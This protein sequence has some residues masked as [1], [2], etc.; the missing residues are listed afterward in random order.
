MNLAYLYSKFFKKI[1]RGKSIYKCKIAPTAVVNS[2]SSMTYS[3]IGRFSYCG[4]DCEINQTDIGAFCSISDHVFIGGDEHPLDWVSTSSMFQAV[5]H[6]G[7]AK[8]FASHEVPKNKRTTIGSDVWIGHGV[9]IKQGV[10]IGHGA[11]IATGAVVTKDVPPYA[12]VGGVPAKVIRY[13]FDEQT[14][15]QLLDSRWWEACEEDIRKMAPY[16]CNPYEF[17]FKIKDYNRGNRI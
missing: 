10:T 13:R 12:I 1:V 7:S 6:S 8:R 3:T 2:G 16:I 4:Y 11:V 9:S 17:L 15:Q 14:C 5:K